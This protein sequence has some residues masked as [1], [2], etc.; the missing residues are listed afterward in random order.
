MNHPPTQTGFASWLTDCGLEALRRKMRI[1]AFGRSAFKVCDTVT[2]LFGAKD[3]EHSNA[4]V[5]AE[6]AEENI[7]TEFVKKQ[8]CSI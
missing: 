7:K 6:W 4:A 2:F 3:A 8:E 1:L 5:L